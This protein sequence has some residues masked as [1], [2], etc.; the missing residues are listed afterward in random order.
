MVTQKSE[1]VQR[2]RQGRP[3]RP[4]RERLGGAG[5][6]RPRR[7]LT[8]SSTS[9]VTDEADATGPTSEGRRHY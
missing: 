3:G 7:H 4:D 1:S 6:Q 5:M 2:G 9:S 8:L